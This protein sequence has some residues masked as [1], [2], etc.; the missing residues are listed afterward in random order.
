MFVLKGCRYTAVAKQNRMRQAVVIVV[1]ASWKE[2]VLVS[3]IQMT[4]LS[5]SDECQVCD[6][7]LEIVLWPYVLME[8]MISAVRFVLECSQALVLK[9]QRMQKTDRM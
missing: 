3:A 4:I 2:V 9:S 1:A 6:V 8:Q 5:A 7:C